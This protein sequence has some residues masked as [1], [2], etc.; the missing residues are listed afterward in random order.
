MEKDEN[1]VQVVTEPKVEPKAQ[2]V[3]DAQ[4]VAEQGEKTQPA[5]EN[6]IPYDRFKEVND[7]KKAAE[8]ER[9]FLRSQMSMQP[10]HQPATLY[11]QVVTELGLKDEPFHTP[12]MTGQIFNKM[13]QYIS[14]NQE[15]AAFVSSHPDYSEVVGTLDPSTG[16]FK[17]AAALQRVISKNPSLAKA[18]FSSPYSRQLAYQ[19][20]SSDPEYIASQ[21]K[22]GITET[23][24]AA[25]DA[26]AAIE[27]A[28]RQAS[29]SAAATG[30]GNLDKAAV[31]SNM[32]K[33]EFAE[34]KAKIIAKAY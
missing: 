17:P 20:A 18:V 34:Y 27:A 23:D 30:G 26:K 6:T 15:A 12:E 8:Q 33:E 13:F 4:V 29:I 31:V 28:Q 10:Q 11:D 24:R 5:T 19:L 7:A 2:D 25:A 21:K 14:V 22:S 32:S 16:Q 1:T 9:D 3:K